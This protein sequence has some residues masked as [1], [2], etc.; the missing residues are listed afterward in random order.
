MS[1]IRQVE[2]IIEECT[3]IFLGIMSELSDHPINL[4]EW[5]Q[6]YAFDVIGAISFNR[7]FG[8]LEERRDVGH[9]IAGLDNR[10]LYFTHCGQVPELHPYL[11]GNKFVPKLQKRFPSLDNLNPMRIVQE[12]IHVR[13]I[14][15]VMVRAFSVC[16]T[17]MF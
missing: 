11:F 5:L 17:N 6:F 9:M 15:I 10:A 2:T 13:F 16:V 3:K 4:G 12:V 8:F 1:S 7:R 14:L